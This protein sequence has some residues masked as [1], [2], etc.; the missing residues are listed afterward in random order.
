VSPSNHLVHTVKVSQ[1]LLVTKAFSLLTTEVVGSAGVEYC[2]KV[3]IKLLV[4][5][6]A[7]S[8]VHNVTLVALALIHTSRLLIA[9]SLT[10]Y[11]A[12]TITNNF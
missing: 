5:N 6:N 4:G 11:F 10:L 3:T 9:L 8:Q 7:H 2:T 12:N 1:D